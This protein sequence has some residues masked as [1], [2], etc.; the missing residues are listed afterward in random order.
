MVVSSFLTSVGLNNSVHHRT[1]SCRGTRLCAQFGF[2]HT[3]VCPYEF[4]PQLINASVIRHH[5]ELISIY[6]ALSHFDPIE[7]SALASFARPY[8]SRSSVP[9]P[10]T[11]SPGPKCC[12]FA[13]REF[14]G[15]VMDGHAQRELAVDDRH[16]RIAGTIR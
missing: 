8:R 5:F 11:Y 4:S 6:F 10:S 13:S 9:V 14:F 3:A 1:G 7:Q 16:G 12:Q 15:V 2:G